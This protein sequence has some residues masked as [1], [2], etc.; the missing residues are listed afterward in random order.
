MKVSWRREDWWNK[1]KMVWPWTEPWLRRMQTPSHR[2][3]M[4]E[5]A[6]EV[7]AMGGRRA[8]EGCAGC[9]FVSQLLLILFVGSMNINLGPLNIFP[10]L[11]GMALSGQQRALERPCRRSLCPGSGWCAHSASSAVHEPW[12]PQHLAPASRA[13]SPK[14]MPL[15]CTVASKTSPQEQLSLGLQ[16]ADFH[17]AQLAWHQWLLCHS[18]SQGRGLSNNRRTSAQEWRLLLG[19]SALGVLAAP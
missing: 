7:Q 8:L 11:P 16:G 15:Q 9:P 5:E 12:F 4:L 19:C 2:Q 17:Q 3:Q 18:A 13:A 1:R 10:L 14:P 6:S